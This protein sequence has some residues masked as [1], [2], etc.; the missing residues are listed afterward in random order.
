M[1]AGGALLLEQPGTLFAA[2]RVVAVTPV[3]DQA[4]GIGTVGGTGGVLAPVLGSEGPVE[5]GRTAHR[6]SKP[7]PLIP[8][9]RT[10][11]K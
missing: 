11:K 7:D 8:S 3:I 4:E 9:D 5:G 1:G 6:K 2:G 10:P